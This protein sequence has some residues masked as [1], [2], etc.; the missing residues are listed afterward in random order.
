MENELKWRNEQRR[1][2]VE[3]ARVMTRE[4][5]D[6]GSGRAL[7]VREEAVA[8]LKPWKFGIWSLASLSAAEVVAAPNDV[9]MSWR[10]RKR[11]NRKIE[12]MKNKGFVQ[13][14]VK[15]KQC[16]W[17]VVAVVE[18]VRKRKWVLFLW[19]RAYHENAFKDSYIRSG[20][21]CA[22]RRHTFFFFLVFVTT[23]V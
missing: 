13:C 10:R 23:R 17:V 5:V 8:G 16:D 3:T 11:E 19:S 12:M 6:E 4:R 22:T 21:V 14:W 7:R 9:V 20:E 2:T 18:L 1:E 15:T